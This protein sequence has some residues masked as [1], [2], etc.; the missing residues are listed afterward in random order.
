[1]LQCK[2]T[3]GNT[4]FI[5]SMFQAVAGMEIGTQMIWIC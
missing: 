3:C 1:M 5:A 2:A 4:T